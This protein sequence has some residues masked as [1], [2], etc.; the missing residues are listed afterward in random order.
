VDI[1]AGSTSAGSK[2]VLLATA[3]IGHVKVEVRQG[4]WKACAAGCAIVNPSNSSL[5]HGAGLAKLIDDVAGAD[6]IEMCQQIGGLAAGS[7]ITT[8]GFGYAAWAHV[9][10][11][12][13]PVC[14]LRRCR[15][16]RSNTFVGFSVPAVPL[17][18]ADCP[19]FTW[20]T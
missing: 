11:A 5:T 16:S 12:H 13:V 10:I 6:Y 19:L 2:Y 18:F 20:N 9:H 1:G 3:D 8:P 17:L 7:A 4:D 14:M 15:R